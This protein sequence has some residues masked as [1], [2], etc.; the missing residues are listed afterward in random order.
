MLNAS[1]DL[2][3]LRDLQD[4]TRKIERGVQNGLD[5]VAERTVQAREDVMHADIYSQPLPDGSKPRRGRNGGILGA[6]RVRKTGPLSREVGPDAEHEGQERGL[7]RTRVDI[8]EKAAGIVEREAA[9]I[10]ERAIEREL[11]G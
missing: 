5:E 4:T 3:A 8:S 1:I 2:S 7:K 9:G 11:R 10:V 6:T